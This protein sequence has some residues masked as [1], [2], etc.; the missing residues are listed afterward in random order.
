[1]QLLNDPTAGRMPGDIEVQDAST[2][3]ADDEEAVE[4]V[5][6]KGGDG[7]EVH[8]RDGFAMITK[9]CPP[10]LGA[11]RISGCELHPAGDGSLGYLKAQHAQFAMNAW[12]TPGGVLG[13][14]LENQIPDFPWDLLATSWLAH[15]AKQCPIQTEPTP[16]PTEHR[17]RSNQIEA[18]FPLGP[19]LAKGNPKQLIEQIQSGFRMPAFQNDELL[20]KSE[21]LQHQ[22]LARTKKATGGSEA[23]PEKIEHGGIVIADRNLIRALMS[24]ISQPD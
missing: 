9:K 1:M 2:V 15:F 8:G 13:H 6:G 17:V 14:H 10:T 23:D 22:V 20:A 5:E 21:V 12:S 3:V 11:F 7:E 24:L 16:V 19:E 4:E 18:L